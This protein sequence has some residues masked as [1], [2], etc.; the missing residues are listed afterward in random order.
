MSIKL[1]TWKIW[2]FSSWFPVLETWKLSNLKTWQFGNLKTRKQENK[3]T[4]KQKIKLEKLTNINMYNSK[5]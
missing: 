4:R 5:N 3:K 2:H 1:E